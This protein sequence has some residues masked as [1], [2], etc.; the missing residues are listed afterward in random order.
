[1][2]HKAEVMD[3]SILYKYLASFIK[4]L[5]SWFK[6]SLLLSEWSL[7]FMALTKAAPSEQAIPKHLILLPFD[8][9]IAKF[10]AKRRFDYT[11][12]Q[13]RTSESVL[14]VWSLILKCRMHCVE[15]I[16]QHLCVANR[17]RSARC[18]YSPCAISPLASNALLDAC[19]A[20]RHDQRRRKWIR[21]IPNILWEQLGRQKKLWS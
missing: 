16:I 7:S 15:T 5:V 8:A 13:R 17:Q 11:R 10:T 4:I 21:R 12:I 19:S 1:M 9:F 2:P 3:W 14:S 18:C 20:W 6:L